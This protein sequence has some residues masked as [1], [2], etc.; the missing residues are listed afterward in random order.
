MPYKKAEEKIK[1]K[2]KGSLSG[3]IIKNKEKKDELL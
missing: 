1:G 3:P 2:T